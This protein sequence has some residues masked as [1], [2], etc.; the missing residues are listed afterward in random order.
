MFRFVAAPSY[1]MAGAAVLVAALAAVA[2][3][4]ARRPPE[5]RPQTQPERSAR[6]AAV[7]V[8]RVEPRSVMKF[9]FVVWLAAFVILF[10][11]WSVPTARWRGWASSI[12][13]SGPYRSFASE[14]T[15][16]A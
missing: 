10:A 7:S 11:G 8:A 3:A 9:S 13:F 14:M 6:Q 1:L 2:G 4:T 5:R 15:W 12:P 16:R